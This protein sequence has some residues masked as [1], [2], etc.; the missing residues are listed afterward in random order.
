[1][2]YHYVRNL[3]CTMLV[4]WNSS[5]RCL[6]WTQCLLSSKL[7]RHWSASVVTS[8]GGHVITLA[9]GHVTVT[10]A[11]QLRPRNWVTSSETICGEWVGN[12]AIFCLVKNS[13]K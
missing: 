6:Q 9:A 11:T 8:P 5:K 12:V 1:M 4:C 3:H 7:S 2:H 13:Q 10:W